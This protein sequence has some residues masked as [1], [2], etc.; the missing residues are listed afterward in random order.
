MRATSCWAPRGWDSG[1]PT[2]S[3]GGH[4]DGTA[5]SFPGDPGGAGTRARPAPVARRRRA[6]PPA[7]VG[8]HRRR[9]RDGRDSRLVR[10]AGQAARHDDH[11]ARRGRHRSES[12]ADRGLSA[13][14]PGAGAAPDGRA[15]VARGREGR[16]HGGRARRRAHVGP[17]ECAAA[18]RLGSRRQVQRPRRP[19]VARRP[20]AVRRQRGV[21]APAGGAGCRVSRRAG[22]GGA[23]RDAAARLAGTGHDPAER[24]SSACTPAGQ[25]ERRAARACGVAGGSID[26]ERRRGTASSRAR[27]SRRC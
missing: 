9:G 10:P 24:R 12:A 18:G 17:V 19:R 16:P 26:P 27:S 25:S 8:A 4:H 14:H 23:G 5:L 20:G 2:G 7:A 3:R 13:A 15:G 6:P 1:A 11:G 21:L 22:C